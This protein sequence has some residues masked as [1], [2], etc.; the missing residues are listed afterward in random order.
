[1]SSPISASVCGE[2]GAEVELGGVSVV[3]MLAQVNITPEGSG[4]MRGEAGLEMLRELGV[5]D[6]RLGVRGR[7]AVEVLRE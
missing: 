3:G 2:V 7:D 1:V 4:S 5:E 6:S